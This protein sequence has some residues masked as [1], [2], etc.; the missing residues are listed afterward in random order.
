MAQRWRD[1]RPVEF[2]PED[3]AMNKWLADEGDYVSLERVRLKDQP[4]ESGRQDADAY[5]GREA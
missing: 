4:R 2:S 5:G 1:R 3:A